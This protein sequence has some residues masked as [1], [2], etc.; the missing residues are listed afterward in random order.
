MATEKTSLP[1]PKVLA[2]SVAGVSSQIV[3]QQTSLPEH[4][5]RLPGTNWAVWRWIVLRGAGFPANE[6][7]KLAAPECAEAAD[8]MLEAEAELESVRE[9]MLEAIRSEFACDN[10]R[11][12]ESLVRALR[13][14]KKGNFPKEL[15]GRAE[16][17]SMLTA[18]HES[19]SELEA[20][21][22]EFRALFKSATDRVSKTMLEIGGSDRFRE[23]QRFS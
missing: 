18:M 7:F 8:A 19:T 4:L 16:F 11:R 2:P 21:R 5:V 23:A 17:E 20:K 12:D 15:E 22:A 3:N 1:N 14:L 13:R 9:Q 6:V 10:G